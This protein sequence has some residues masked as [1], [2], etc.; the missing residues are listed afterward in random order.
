MSS[1][2][3][4]SGRTTPHTNTCCLDRRTTYWTRTLPDASVKISQRAM[5]L[6][7]ELETAEAGLLPE[8]Q[9]H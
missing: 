9:R 8:A 4:V 5:L 2:T 3:G 1:S 7:L 6:L